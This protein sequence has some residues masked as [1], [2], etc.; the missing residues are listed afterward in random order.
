[1]YV[2]CINQDISAKGWSTYQSYL[3]LNTVT[4]VQDLDTGMYINNNN[5]TGVHHTFGILACNLLTGM[6]SSIGCEVLDPRL[7]PEA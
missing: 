7:S 4:S 6:S 3:F 5:K 2:Q 1:M